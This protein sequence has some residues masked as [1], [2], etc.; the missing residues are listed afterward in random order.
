MQDSIT[1]IKKKIITFYHD[2]LKIR[3]YEGLQIFT[4]L[5]SLSFF[6]AVIWEMVFHTGCA[7]RTIIFFSWIL[8]SVAAVGLFIFRY[9]FLLYLPV[10]KDSLAKFALA[11]GAAFPVIQDKLLNALQIAESEINSNNPFTLAAIKQ[12]ES[13][14]APLDFS[15][16]LDTRKLKKLIRVAVPTGILVLFF[17]LASTEAR[18]AAGRILLYQ[19]VFTPPQKFI[20][21]IAPGN[22]SIVRGTSIDGTIFTLGPSPRQFK[23]YSKD[24]EQTS[25]TILSISPD[26]LGLFRFSLKNVKSNLAYYAEAEGIESE[27][28]LVTVIDKPVITSFSISVTP[29]AYTGLPSVQMQDNGNITVLPGTNIRFTVTGSKQLKSA[30][31]VADDTLRHP[32]SITAA[33]ATGI[34]RILNGM[35]YYINLNDFQNNSNENPV[36]YTI[37]MM[38]DSPPLIEVLSPGI[39]SVLSNEQRLAINTRISDDYGFTYLKLFYRLSAS[40]YEQPQ[41]SY[42]SISLPIGKQKGEQITQ[43]IWNLSPMNLAT[44]DIVS[45]YLELADNNNVNGP[46]K[47]RSPEMTVRVP[48]LQE[49]YSHNDQM[50]EKA[51]NTLR[52]TVKDAQEL[53]KDIEQLSRDLRKDKQSVSWDEKEK[54]QDAVKR[55]NDLQKKAEETR[56]ELKEAT[57]DLQKNNLLSKETL[58]KYLELQNLMKEL[59]SEEMKK[60]ME[61]LQKSLQNLDRK[62]IQ[63][64]LANMKFDEEMI[65]KSLERTLNLLKRV[66][67][68]QKMDEL[69]KETENIEKQQNTLSEEQSKQKNQSATKEDIARQKEIGEQTRQ[70][71]AEMKQLAERMKKFQDMPNDKMEQLEKELS[72]DNNDELSQEAQQEMQSGNKSS[73][74]QKQQQIARNMQKTRKNLQSLQNSMMQQQQMQTLKD[75]L[76]AVNDI[77]SLSKQEEELKKASGQG[78][79]KMLFSE[80]ARKQDN[81][82]GNLDN[83]MQSLGKLAQKTFAI[84]PEMGKE[85]GD[86]RRQM[87][88]AITSLQNRNGSAANIQQNSAMESLNHAANMLKQGMESMM[89]QGGGQGSGMMSLMQ[90][91]GKMSGQQMSLNNMTQKLMQGGNGQLSAQQQAQMQRLAQQQELIKKSMEQLEK[92]ARFSGQSKKLPGNLNDITRQMEE[93]I[94]EMRTNKADDALVQKQ[95]RILSKM[96]DIQRSA[97]ERDFEK[98][99]ESFTGNNVNRQSPAELQ[100]QKAKE[101][102]LRDEI[103]RAQKEGYSRDYEEL[104]KKYLEKIEKD[105][106]TK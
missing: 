101:N 43:F 34:Q 2:S 51:E 36:H 8:I 3:V 49:L 96:L 55:F 53:K 105:S 17:V 71:E 13:E 45:F 25:P 22:C 35:R 18:E 102:K 62:Q 85:M 67:I 64:D 6:F 24:K 11:A 90:Q 65:Q 23:L 88:N 75:M 70:L 82:R 99:R 41:S 32:L 26:S 42:E 77:I 33:T 81:I 56:K 59:S 38:Y 48:S 52:N 84:T 91:L 37:S 97:N 20:I 19:H 68:E 12:V 98:E 103:I 10:T 47:A 4:L 92:E 9:L 1:Y 74:R 104:I 86:A 80:N 72:D 87:E 50:Q 93:V 44:G 54:I 16:T 73:S 100:K 14:I 7:F 89:Q 57:S 106:N 46:Q 69:V 79:S 29:P 60:A 28:Y 30:Y 5:S 61:R 83:V 76:R 21:R 40:R 95:E 66:Q 39:N 78:E 15:A 27:K 31:I 94:S 58:E 63:Q